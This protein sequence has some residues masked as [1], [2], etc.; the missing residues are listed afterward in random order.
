MSEADVLKTQDVAN[1]R[2]HVER[3]IGQLKDFSILV[4]QMP[5]SLIPLADDIIVVCAA[6]HNLL[7]PLVK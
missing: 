7:P 3:A 5:I 2:I 1:T 4:H 6:L